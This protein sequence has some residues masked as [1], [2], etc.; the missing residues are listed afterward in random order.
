MLSRLL[1]AICLAAVSLTLIKAGAQEPVAAC[2]ALDRPNIDCGCVGVRIETLASAAPQPEGKTV[3]RQAYLANLGRDNTFGEAMSDLQQSNPMNIVLL[4]EA[5]APFGGRPENIEEFEAGCVIPEAAPISFDLP[6]E[7]AVSEYVSKCETSTGDARYCTCD[8]ARKRSRVSAQGFEAY[9]GSFT[10]YD[11]ENFSLEEMTKARADAMGLSTDAYTELLSEARAKIDSK[12]E[13]DSLYCAATLWADDEPGA[14]QVMRAR[15]GFEADMVDLRKAVMEDKPATPASKDDTSAEAILI[16]GCSADGNSESYCACYM[17]DYRANVA[18]LM[19]DADTAKAWALLNYGGG[20]SRTA[21]ME[22]VRSIPQAAHERAGML[23]MSTM[24]VGS[25]CTQ[26][27]SAVD[28]PME[29]SA[30]ERMMA[31][32]IAENEDEALCG[33][34][35]DQMQE[36]LSEDDFELI[37]DLREAEYRGVEDP[38][39]HIAEKRGLTRDEAEQALGMNQSMMG[40]LMGMD[41]MACMGGIPGGFTMPG[42]PR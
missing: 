37:V 4:E 20:L 32:C 2:E 8:A 25:S 28:A 13:K 23:M 18:P 27:P 42:G 9:L 14:S 35:V 39:A 24:D 17:E 38:L 31:V 30:R 11:E 26:G 41:M 1:P 36:K 21:Y 3:I 34:M 12:S 19:P 5:L 29:G 10:Q 6:D 15:G 33:C 40:A 16:S 7:P 22:A